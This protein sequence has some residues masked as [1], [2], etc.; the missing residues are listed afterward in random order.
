MSAYWFQM[1]NLPTTHPGAH[2]ALFAGEFG[3]QRS[4]KPFAQVAVDQTIEQSMNRHSKMRKG[5]TV[6]FSK[7]T[8]SNSALAVYS[9]YDRLQ[10]TSQCHNLAGLG[11]GAEAGHK[12]QNPQRIQHDEQDVQVLMN[13]LNDW[14]HPFSNDST[15]L[16]S[17]SSTGVAPA[18][19]QSDLEQTHC[20]GTA[21]F[22]ALVKDRLVKNKAKF[23]DPITQMQLKTF[24]SVSV[25]K[26]V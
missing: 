6:W 20:K 10:I 2:Q 13:P 17:L 12:D 9:P 26:K 21:A 15:H 3:A 8:I 4:M 24:R 5:L 14:V 18:E 7:K 1:V 16:T 23:L 11:N 22:V 19:V 25:K